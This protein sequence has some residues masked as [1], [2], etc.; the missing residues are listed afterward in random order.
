M[1]VQIQW[2][3]GSTY[4][5]RCTQHDCDLEGGGHSMGLGYEC[6]DGMALDS[7]VEGVE[8]WMPDSS[9]LHCP[10]CQEDEDCQ[11]FWELMASGE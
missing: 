9:E 4:V 2:I 11:D 6:F 3:D 10:N 7:T 8:T 5:W 1:T